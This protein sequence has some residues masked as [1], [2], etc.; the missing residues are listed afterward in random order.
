MPSLVVRADSTTQ[1]GT[2]SGI[3]QIEPL[4]L[5]ADVL[6]SKHYGKGQTPSAKIN[7]PGSSHAFH[8]YVVK[9]NLEHRAHIFT[10]LRKADIGVNVHYIPVYLH[11]YYREKFNI[12][13][14]LCPK[15]E[16]PYKGILSL[17]I[18]PGLLDQQVQ[19]IVE[20][21]MRAL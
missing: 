1:I 4:T 8:L 21:V 12:K 7:T 6:S 5:R 18:F 2:F 3:P 14:G 16:E 19:E 20:A 13:P 10:A 15:V 11:P 17:P 9:V